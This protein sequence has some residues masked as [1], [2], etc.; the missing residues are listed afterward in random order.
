MLVHVVLYLLMGRTMPVMGYR[1]H[2]HIINI[3][4]HTPTHQRCV[5]GR[6]TG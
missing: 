6:R 4:V 2:T 1:L 3:H 5:G